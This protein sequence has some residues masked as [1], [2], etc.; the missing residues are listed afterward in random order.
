[1]DLL[2]PLDSTV[3]RTRIVECRTPF[4]AELTAASR[5]QVSSDQQ[6]VVIFNKVISQRDATTAVVSDFAERESANLNGA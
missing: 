3:Q 4:Q 6:P 2:I 1:M 5:K